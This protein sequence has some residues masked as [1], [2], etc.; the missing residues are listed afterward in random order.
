MRNLLGA[1]MTVCSYKSMSCMVVVLKMLLSVYSQM[2]LQIGQV[3]E[4]S[5]WY[6]GSSGLCL[7]CFQET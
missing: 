1:L 5:S 7:L 3:L 4:D 2:R 6:S